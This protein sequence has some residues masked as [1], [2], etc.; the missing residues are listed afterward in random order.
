MT[1]DLKDAFPHSPS[2]NKTYHGVARD[3]ISSTEGEVCFFSNTVTLSTDMMRREF[4]KYVLISLPHHLMCLCVSDLMSIP[5]YPFHEIIA[6]CCS[7]A[8][9]ESVTT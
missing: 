8:L 4:F 9:I 1:I 5:L 3:S 7:A 6:V 2:K